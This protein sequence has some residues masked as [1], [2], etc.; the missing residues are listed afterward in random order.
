MAKDNLQDIRD[1]VGDEEVEDALAKLRAVKEEKVRRLQKEK[2]RF[3]TPNGK[4]E[5]FIKAVGSGDNFITLF[6]AANG[7]GKTQVGA[8]VVANIVF[9]G[10]NDEWFDQPLFKNWPYPKRGRIASNAANLPQVLG[11]LED[12][13]PKGKYKAQKAGKTYK[14]KWQAGEWEFDVMSYDQ[15]GEQFEGPTLGFIWLDE[16]P[17]EEIYKACVSR[18]RMGGVMFITATMLKG[19]G[20]L[21]DKIVAGDVEVEGIDG[22][23]IKRQVK[24]MTAG[25]EE[26]C[27]EHGVRGHLMHA[28]I[29]RMIAEYD[30]DEREARVFGRSQH[31]VGRIFKTF[32]RAI[33]VI[34]PFQVTLRDYCVVEALDPH[35]RNPDAIMWLAVDRWGRK[36]VVDELYIKCQNGTEEL[37]QL[38]KEKAEKYRIIYRQC[39]LSGWNE[40]QHEKDPRGVAVKLN[41]YDLDYDKAPKMRE[42]ADSRIK[43]ALAYTKSPNGEF[44]KNPEL[45]IFETCR[46]TIWEVENY[47]WDEWTGKSADKHNAKEKPLDK[48]DHEIEN[49]GRCLVIEPVFQAMPFNFGNGDNSNPADNLDPYA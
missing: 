14:S 6:S 4:C 30:P 25:V 37:A 34:K 1:L 26:A 23:K 2:C 19:S 45:Y 42:A 36:F 11:A 5:E 3:Y 40:N 10:F 16:P 46:R 39:D 29:Q 13:F 49:L 7:V 21:Y 15:S 33:H 18:L 38:I 9:P 48:D 27:V 24:Y 8:N 12:W 32:D 44:I 20:W 28:D 22:E 41:D 35:P 43:D 31:L 17:T 47:R